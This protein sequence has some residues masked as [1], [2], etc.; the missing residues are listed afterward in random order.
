[1]WFVEKNTS[2]TKVEHSY[3]ETFHQLSRFELI[4]ALIGFKRTLC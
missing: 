1:M 4:P 3:T 2:N